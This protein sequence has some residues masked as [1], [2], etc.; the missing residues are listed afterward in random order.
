M[1]LL[2]LLWLLLLLLLLA[3]AAAASAAVVAIAASAAATALLLVL[4]GVFVSFL[5]SCG[6]NTRDKMYE[7]AKRGCCC[8]FCWCSD[9]RIHVP[10]L[11]DTS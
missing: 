8:Y 3:S 1:L 7:Y 5:L 9:Q 4:L 11:H 10:V 2:L 6:T